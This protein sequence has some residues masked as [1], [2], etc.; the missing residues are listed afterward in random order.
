MKTQ[1][2]DSFKLF[3][4]FQNFETIYK[5]FDVFIYYFEF[6]YIRLNQFSSQLQELWYQNQIVHNM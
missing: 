3:Y 6:L 5:K 2:L 1:I 4:F